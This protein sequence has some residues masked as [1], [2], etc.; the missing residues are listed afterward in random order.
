MFET[1]AQQFHAF[2]HEHT[3]VSDAL[4]HRHEYTR[5]V[6]HCLEFTFTLTQTHL[7]IDRVGLGQIV[8]DLLDDV[9][10]PTQINHHLRTLLV[11]VHLG[12]G[13]TREEK[14]NNFKRM[15]NWQK[16]KPTRKIIK[17]C[18]VCRA[19][20]KY[21]RQNHAWTIHHVSQLKQAKHWEY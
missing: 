14:N 21:S 1:V 13:S 2:R 4:Q 12:E 6:F 18:T 8:A 11:H 10:L 16:T 9:A 20:E 17:S 7:A 19:S 5:G 3:S 15:H